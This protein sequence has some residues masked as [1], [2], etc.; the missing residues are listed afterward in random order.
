M[1]ERLRV[2]DEDEWNAFVQSHPRGTFFHLTGWK[3]VLEGSLH[4]RAHYLTARRGGS[5]AGVLPLI[6]I[7]SRLFGHALLSTAF[8]VAGGPLS[9]DSDGEIELLSAAESIARE[10]NVDYVE[11]KDTPGAPEGWLARQDLYA[12]FERP[13]SAD[14]ATCLTQIPRKQ[15]AVVR[16]SLTSGLTF[17]LDSDVNAVFDL[18]ARTVRDHG[19]P[20]FPKALFQSLKDNFGPACE[21]LTVRK[22]GMPIS[23]VMSFY[24]RDR[25]LPYYTGS[26]P[27]ARDTGANDLMYW[28]L[29]RRASERGCTIFDFGRS[30]TGTG[31]YAFKK[32]WGFPARPIPHQ[33][34][35][36]RLKVLPSLNPTNPKFHL[37][38]RM[39]QR[40]PLSVAN[41]VGP[42]ISRNL[43]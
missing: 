28:R 21:V 16:K 31:P 37:L 14:E 12:G 20:V 24:Y 9:F 22:G 32:N 26:L 5:I 2:Q 41:M 33:F 7:K 27:S 8:C 42:F 4:H 15:R 38:V 35:L 40:L 43:G 18:Y 13:I 23:S 3:N 17:T 29:M 25:V 36:N 34:F 30:K 39:W 11:L 1:T 6:E 19:T 10:L